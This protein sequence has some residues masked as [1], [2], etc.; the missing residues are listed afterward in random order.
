MANYTVRVPNGKEYGP[1]DL[2]TVKKWHTEGRIGKDALVW[3]EG[4]PEWVPLARVLESESVTRPVRRPSPAAEPR[5]AARPRP[6]A[7]TSPTSGVIL[8]VGSLI[9]VTAGVGVLLAYGLPIL[10]RRRA[11][12]E[13]QQY[14]SPERRFAD[15]ELGLAVELPE[16]WWMLLPESS[17]VVAPEARLKLAEPALGAFAVLTVEALPHGMGGSLDKFVDHIREARRP[18]YPDEKE[19]GRSD[20]TVGGKH[21]ARLVQTTWAADGKEMRGSTAVWRDGWNYFALRAWCPGREAARMTPELE[22]LLRSVLI[23]GVLST[24][25]RQ[26]VD[27]LLL[28]APELS[29]PAAEALVQDRLSIGQKADDLAQTHVQAVSRGLRALSTEETHALAEIYAQVYAP[30]PEAERV[31][32]ARYL[33]RVKEGEFVRPEEGQAMRQLL[34]DGV[35]GLPGEVRVRLQALNEKAIAAGLSG[36]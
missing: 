5:P 8:L 13:I 29:R 36:S 9:A 27:Q 25:V 32:L 26:V 18:R 30:I 33:E 24:R 34:R 35:M 10:Q 17:L 12:A 22:A 3:E 28:E 14:T 11:L 23:K 15:N 31:R 19:L 16:G 20:T 6:R 1:V 21:A 7:T 2:A 4:A